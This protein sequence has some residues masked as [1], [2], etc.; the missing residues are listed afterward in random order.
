MVA[1]ALQAEAGQ[2]VAR[3]LGPQVAVVG[4]QR[5]PRHALPPGAGLELARLLERVHAHL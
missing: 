2:A 3:E 1:A 5:A 4:Q